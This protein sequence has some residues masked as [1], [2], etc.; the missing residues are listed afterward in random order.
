M[1]QQ[2]KHQ[3]VLGRRR[4]VAPS[5]P[6]RQDKDVEKRVCIVTNPGR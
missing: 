5:N 2:K 4:L 6:V 1:G 3:A